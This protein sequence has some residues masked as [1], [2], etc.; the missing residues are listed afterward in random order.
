[1]EHDW[2][3]QENVHIIIYT[4]EH[5]KLKRDRKKTMVQHVAFFCPI[6]PKRIKGILALNYRRI[7]AVA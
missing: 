5:L 7:A 3:N 2:F 6:R 4:A 1:M